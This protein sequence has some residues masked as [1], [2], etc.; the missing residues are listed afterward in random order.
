M[1]AKQQFLMR[2]YIH[3]DRGVNVLLGKALVLDIDLETLKYTKI[4]AE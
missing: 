4:I 3:L 2:I 1:A